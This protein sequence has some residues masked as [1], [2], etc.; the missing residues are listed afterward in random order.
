MLEAL[1][2]YFKRQKNP[3][4][5]RGILTG[6]AM[7]EKTIVNMKAGKAGS[8]SRGDGNKGSLIS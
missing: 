5:V 4:N 1:Q 3:N 6:S 8:L 2:D 7:D